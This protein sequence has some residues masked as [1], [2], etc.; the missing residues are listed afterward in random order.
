[1]RYAD[2][3]KDW[4][5]YF[6]KSMSHKSNFIGMART[7]RL[8]LL[9]VSEFG[10]VKEFSQFILPATVKIEGEQ[11]WDIYALTMYCDMYRLC[12][13]YRKP[14]DEQRLFNL[15][16]SRT[17]N[18]PNGW[19][20]FRDSAEWIILCLLLSSSPVRRF[21][22]DNLAQRAV[23]WLREGLAQDSTELVAE[24]LTILSFLGIGVLADLVPEKLEYHQLLERRRVLWLEHAFTLSADKDKA[25]KSWQDAC[26]FSN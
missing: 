2:G 23:R 5:A 3:H 18:P 17:P 9:M 6:R 20:D 25:W 4:D 1:M 21:Q 26:S 19:K 24:S 8:L 7:Q 22:L 15:L 10:P 14:V 12:L 13:A 11:Q 16:I